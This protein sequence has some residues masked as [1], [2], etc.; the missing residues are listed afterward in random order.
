MFHLASEETYQNEE[1]IFKEGTPGTWVY[2]IISG[3]VEISRMVNGKKIVFEVLN[4]GELFGEFGFLGG[5]KRTGTARSMGETT[6]GIIE[7]EYLDQEYNKLTSEFRSILV[8]M[9]KRFEKLLDRASGFSERK[10]KRVLKTL[11]LTFKTPKSF[12]KAYTSNLDTE[13]LFIKTGNPL[14]EGDPFLLK[15][16]LPGIPM[17]IKIKCDVVWTRKFQA[18]TDK[19]PSGMGVKF[20][21]MTKKDKK[22]LEEYLQAYADG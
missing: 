2:F 4:E 21:Q 9:V 19:R 10:E 18:G 14:K 6:V 7:R 16:Q 11:A 3:A 1:I 12:L 13:G 8:A 15:L 17:P 22:F 5:I 20:T